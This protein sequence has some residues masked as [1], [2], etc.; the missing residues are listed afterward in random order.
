[1][2]Y[3]TQQLQGGPKYQT[4]VKVGNWYE[5]MELEEIKGNDYEMRKTESSLSLNKTETNFSQGSKKVPQTFSPDGLLRFGD[6]IMLSNKQTDSCLVVNFSERVET[7]E[8]AYSCTTSPLITGPSARCIFII[9]RVEPNDGFDD[10]VVH[11]GQQVRFVTN[12]YELNKKLWLRSTPESPMHKSP[13]S[14]FQEVCVTNMK[15]FDTVWEIEDLDPNTRFEVNGDAVSANGPVLIKHASTCHFLASERLPQRN[16]YGEEFEVCVHSFATQNKSQNLELEF[17]GQ[18]TRDTPSK[19]QFAQNVW[20]LVTAPDATY[21]CVDEQN[22]AAF[23]IETLMKEVKARLAQRSSFGIRG[24][25]RI[26]RA[27]DDNGNGQLDQDDFRWGLID[28]GIAL[29]KEEASLLLTA[30]DRDGN[31]T[32]SFDEFLRVIKGDL[33]PFREAL[34]LRAYHEKLDVNHDG[35]VTLADVASIYD[36]SQHPEV[37]EGKKSEEDVFKEFMQKWDTQ[38]K[39]GVVTAD[40]FLDYFKDVSA[41]IDRDDYFE[42][43]M[44]QAWKLE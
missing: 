44:K 23:K 43:M 27:M 5:D 31:G 8:E 15:T 33:N 35:Q 14:G 40:E 28:F 6:K 42:L 2:L 17:K 10:N 9:E 4:K 39:D 11:L 19:F 16:T 37:A 34:I 12:T 22:D 13:V 36:A 29:S 1:M 24:L 38:D 26:F 18:T 21:D 25:A 3:T 41:S 7:Y 32:I 30:Y 20:K